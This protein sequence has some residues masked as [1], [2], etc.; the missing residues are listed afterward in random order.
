MAIGIVFFG[1]VALVAC[2]SVVAL[3]VFLARN[4]GSKRRQDEQDDEGW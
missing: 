4:K 1:A 2:A 3:V